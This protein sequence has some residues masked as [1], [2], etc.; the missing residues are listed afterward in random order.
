MSNPAELPT[1]WTFLD[2]IT[3]NLKSQRL[4][5]V[6]RFIS[7]YPF[8]TYGPHKHLRLEINHVKK[9]NCMMH[10]DNESINFVEGDTM[11]ILS[12]V[13]HVFEAGSGGTTL[14]QLEFLPEIF[15]G[16]DLNFPGCIDGIG[17]GS[18]SPFSEENKLIKIV[19]NIGIMRVVQRIVNELEG[20]NSYYQYLVVMYYAELLV[21]IYRYMS[22]N[23]LPIC[24][25]DALKRAISF[26][27]FNYHKDISINDVAIQAD[28][29]ERYLRSLFSQYLNISPLD[30]L[31]QI[32]INKS[33]ELLRNTELSVKEIC[34][35]CGFQSPQY[36]SRI[37]KQQTGISPREVAK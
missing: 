27:R 1:F 35:Q 25:N 26:I 4:A 16:F 8:E 36:F 6:F 9:G 24:Q 12:N 31:N 33:I 10:L 5:D 28:I 17:L 13:N 22:E 7:F 3:N 14:M 20:K 37:F 11:I 2:N 21:L 30:Y 29:S 19:N 32:R 23:Y 34:F 18:I 15:S